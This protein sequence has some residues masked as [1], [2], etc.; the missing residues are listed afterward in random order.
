L[1]LD[2]LFESLDYLEKAEIKPALLN[3]VKRIMIVHGE[4][5]R[6]VP[7]EEAISIK[8]NLSHARFVCMRDTGHIP[9]LRK[10]LAKVI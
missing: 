4:L 10:D 8:E 3:E 6:I 5:D 7:I 9:F 1:S 2:N